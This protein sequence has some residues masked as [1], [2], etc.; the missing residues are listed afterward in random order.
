[1]PCALRVMVSCARAARTVLMERASS[2]APD[3]L[4]AG[5][6]S[7]KRHVVKPQRHVVKT[8][9]SHGENLSVMW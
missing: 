3:S 9:A 2:S 1:M 8:S 4:R 5:L 6:C 7:D